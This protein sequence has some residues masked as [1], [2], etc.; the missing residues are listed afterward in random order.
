MI[1]TLPEILKE[2][3]M[4]WGRKWEGFRDGGHIY[5]HG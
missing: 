3:Y 5:T 4:G 2:K 1:E